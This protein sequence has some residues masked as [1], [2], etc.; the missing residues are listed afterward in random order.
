MLIGDNIKNVRK[1]KGLKQKDLAEKIGVSATAI[2]RY[3]KGQREPDKETIE[4]IA[5]A[6]KVAPSSLMSWDKWDEE[7]NINGNEVARFES[8]INYLKSL[9]YEYKCN[10]MEILDSSVQDEFDESGNIIGRSTV[11]EDAI[12]SFSLTKEDV[13]TTF[14]QEEFE[15]LQNKCNENIDGLV[16]LQN[17]KNKKES[18]SAAT[19]ND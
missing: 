17:Q 2:M 7:F 14:S 15:I 9:G 19:D 1:S 11:I 6:L 12:Y 4:K 18:S 5:L 13:T 10:V 16:L 8:F 3:E